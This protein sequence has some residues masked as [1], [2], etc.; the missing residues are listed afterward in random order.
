MHGS[1]SI[2]VL[3]GRR[4]ASSRDRGGRHPAAG[5]AAAVASVALRSAGSTLQN[6]GHL[7]RHA[8]RTRPAAGV[9]PE[10]S[11]FLARRTATV[12][13]ARG[14]ERA[15]VV[16][17]ARWQPRR[18]SA[19]PD[20]LATRRVGVDRSGVSE[21]LWLFGASRTLHAGLRLYDLRLDSPE[22]HRCN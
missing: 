16:A 20:R 19:G 7:A 4:A 18:G 8:A 3:E 5:A 12:G 2:R 6:D 13:K 1:R 14:P 10:I 9:S 22:L 21:L 15:G 17:A 11:V